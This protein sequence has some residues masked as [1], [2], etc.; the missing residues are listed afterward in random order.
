MSVLHIIVPLVTMIGVS[1]FFFSEYPYL[2]N[3]TVLLEE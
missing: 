1:Q 3:D 2:Q